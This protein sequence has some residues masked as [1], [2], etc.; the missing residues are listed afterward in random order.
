M[1]ATGHWYAVYTRPHQEGCAETNLR[2]QGFATYLPR[3]L[4]RRRHARRTDMVSRPLFPRYIFVNLDSARDR[5]R[6]IHSTF[7]VSHIVLAGDKPA[8]VPAAMIKDI[9]AREDD[10]GFVTLGLPA[11]V[12]P[13]SPVRVIDGIFTDARGVLE[14]ITSKR[15]VAILMTLL[16]REV[17]FIVPAASI[18]GA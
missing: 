11:G 4:R 14:H 6:V 8:P 13:G 7:G 18:G 16:G 1:T 2:R 10:E 3:Y 12:A 17:R 15:R 9:R 5:W